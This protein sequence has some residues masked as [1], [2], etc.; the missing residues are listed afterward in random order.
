MTMGI[1]PI[2]KIYNDWTIPHGKYLLKEK[3]TRSEDLRW[4]SISTTM[5]LRETVCG[6]LVGVPKALSLR[7][8]NTHVHSSSS[9]KG[10]KSNLIITKIKFVQNYSSLKIS[11]QLFCIFWSE[12]FHFLIKSEPRYVHSAAMWLFIVNPIGSGI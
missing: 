11:L 1:F 3:Y 8:I 7:C 10:Q 4:M 5:E 9:S 6:G 2:N 12:N